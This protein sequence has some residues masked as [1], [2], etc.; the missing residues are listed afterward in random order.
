MQRS[1]LWRLSGMGFE[2][3][4]HILAGLILGWLVDRW[5]GTAPLW[6]LIGAGMGLAVGMAQ[7]IRSALKA[8]REA[9]RR[10]REQRRAPDGDK[11]ERGRNQNS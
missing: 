2:L 4:S 1:P 9:L 8:N 7:F 11:A 5:A 6:L 10:A 3:L